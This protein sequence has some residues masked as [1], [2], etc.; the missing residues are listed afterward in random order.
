MTDFVRLVLKDT[1]VVLFVKLKFCFVFV[2]K[3]WVR[4]LVALHTVDLYLLSMAGNDEIFFN[5]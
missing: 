3:V 4:F 2:F 1:F 5:S